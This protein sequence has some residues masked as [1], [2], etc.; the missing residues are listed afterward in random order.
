MIEIHVTPE[1]FE[2][3]LRMLGRLWV[4]KRL[5]GGVGGWVAPSLASAGTIVYKWERS[6]E[7]M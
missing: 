3:T 5:F 4:G 6:K 7:D 1:K 2:A